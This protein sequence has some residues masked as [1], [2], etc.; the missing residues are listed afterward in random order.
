MP[1]VNAMISRGQME[2]LVAIVA[3]LPTRHSKTDARH[4]EDGT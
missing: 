4:Q 1:V 2:Q 3:V